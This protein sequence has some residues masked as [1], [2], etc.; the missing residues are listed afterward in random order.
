MNGTEHHPDRD[1]GHPNDWSGYGWIIAIE[2]A[3]VVFIG[4]GVAVLVRGASAADPNDALRSPTAVTISL[5]S[6][7]M[8]TADMYRYAADHS[9]QFA[10]IPCYCGC[11][12]SLGH[13]NLEDCFVTADGSWDAHASGC[14]VCTIEAS[15]AQELIDAGTDTAVVRQAIIDRYGPPPAANP[16]GTQ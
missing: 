12:R 11:D 2:L 1:P 6:L 4:L 14:A 5:A 16:G 7:P 8:E 10:Q 9:E 13:R 15:A 3:L